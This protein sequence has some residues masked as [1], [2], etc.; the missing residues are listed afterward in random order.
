GCKHW[1]CMTCVAVHEG[2]NCLEY[3]EDLKLRAMNDATARK[4]QEH[5][6]EMIKRREAMY[7]PGCRVIIQKLSGCDWLQCT[8]CKME[9]CWPTRG[10]RWGPGGRGDTSGGC[11]CRADKGKLCTKDCQNCH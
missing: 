2:Q 3:Q 11:R 8:Q 6:E 7:C 1:I 10:P 9:I 4:D 5:L